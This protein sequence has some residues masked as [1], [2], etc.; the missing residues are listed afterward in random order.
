MDTKFFMSKKQN[1]TNH[2]IEDLQK[3][4]VEKQEELRRLSFAAQGSKN[5]NVKAPRN[6]RKEVARALTEISARRPQD[7]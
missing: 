7:K 6:L 3:L 2:S 4:V 1:L 5:R